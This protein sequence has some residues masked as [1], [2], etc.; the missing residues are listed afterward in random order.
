MD[1]SQDQLIS[2]RD[3]LEPWLLKQPGFNGSG[4]GM[5]RGGNLVIK[6]YS[7]RMPAATRD[8]IVEKAGKLPIEIEE[9]GEFRAQPG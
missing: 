9:T 3:K 2:E 5:S 4:I 1:Y 8:A 7:N 6:V